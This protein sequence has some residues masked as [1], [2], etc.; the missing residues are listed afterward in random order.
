REAKN[1]MRFRSWVLYQ[2]LRSESRTFTRGRKKKRSYVA[3]V[4]RRFTKNIVV[5]IIANSKTF[6]PIQR[7][8]T[9]LSDGTVGRGERDSSSRAFW[10]K[11]ANSCVVAFSAPTR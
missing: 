3:L 10:A 4:R 11:L 6:A 2:V 8:H 1:L 9:V 7:L 5:P